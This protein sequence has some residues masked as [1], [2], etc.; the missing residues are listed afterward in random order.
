ML[1]QNLKITEVALL[2][3]LHIR[4]I[5]V[6]TIIVIAGCINNPPI[7]TKVKTNKI[8]R[9]LLKASTRIPKL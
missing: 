4:L 5:G 7:K 2:W 1:C 6:K 8:V 3:T 9:S